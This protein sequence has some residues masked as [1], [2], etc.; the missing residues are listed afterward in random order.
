[1]RAPKI[2]KLAVKQHLFPPNVRSIY[3]YIYIWSIIISPQLNPS[4]AALFFIQCMAVFFTFFFPIETP[5]R[6]G[7][8]MRRTSVAEN[9]IL[10]HGHRRALRGIIFP[11]VLL[12]LSFN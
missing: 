10:S 2:R 6:G 8:G 12:I 9:R 3:I 5:F 4:H 7:W 11:F 1:M